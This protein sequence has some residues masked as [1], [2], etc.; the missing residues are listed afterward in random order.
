MERFEKIAEEK[1]IEVAKWR[2]FKDV[3]LLFRPGIIKSLDGGYQL[4]HYGMYKSYF[5]IGWR[6]LAKQRMYS[7]I[8]VGG[9]AIGIAAC[10]L[11]ALYIHQELNYD[12][13]FANGDRIYRVFRVSSFK[14]DVSRGAFF[15]SPFATTLAEE[16]PEIEQTG[17][18]RLGIGSYEVRCSDMLESSNEENLAFVDQSLLDIL[19]VPFIH[20]NPQNALSEPNTIVIT[21]S[22]S[23]KYFGDND[24][25]GKIF[26]LN[27]DESKQYKVTGVVPDFPFTSH[28]RYDFLISLAGREM[29]N[30][31][32]FNYLTYV[33]VRP[34]ADVGALEQKLISLVESYF[35]PPRIEM[36]LDD[37]I[38]WVKSFKFGL[39]P[40]QD[41]YLN[42]DDLGDNLKH[43]NVEYLWLFGSIATI[44]L[45]IACINFINLSTARSANRAKEIGIRKV[46]GSQRSSLIQQLLVES[47]MFSFFSFVLGMV[48]ALLLL[49]YFNTLISKTLIFPWYEWWWVLVMVTG[50]LL[51]GILAG[52]YPAFYLSSFR[53]ILVLKGDVRRGVE[54]SSMRSTLVIFQFTISIILIICTLIIDR[55]MYYVLNKQLGF[56]KEQVLLLHGTQTLGNKISVFK[57]EL[58]KLPKITS[59]SISEYLP[60]EGF[61]TDNGGWIKVGEQLDDAV[62]GQ[63]WSVDHDYV[64]TM[65]LKIVRGRDFSAL[66]PTDSQAVIINESLVKELNLKDPIGEQ[67][68]NWKGDWTVIGVVEDF[69]FESM[70]KEIRPLGMYM[71]QSLNTISIKMNTTDMGAMIRSVT[72]LWNEF[73]PNQTIRYSF[74]DQ[75][76][77][78]M[79]ED[80][81][82][83]RSIFSIFAILAIIVACLGLFA[84]S[85]FL[86]EQR[87][88]EISIRLVLGASINNILR[89]IVQNFLIL[90]I[91]SFFIAIPIAWYMMDQWLED[92]KYRIQIGWEVF[93][94][95]G[96]MAASIAIFTIS[97]QSIRAAF[98]NPVD[99]L[100]NE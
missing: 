66:M 74:L 91:I 76:Y 11:I 68:Y 63:H 95:A 80:V 42:L 23:A 38:K 16:Y 48:L 26:I 22:K 1:G 17:R 51:T 71:G 47:C 14:G 35:L 67:I 77:A 54:T 69:H 98:M 87:S 53:P 57:N 5:K 86:V 2:F 28:F 33:L 34:K 73:A 62:F 32:S 30:W 3:L 24:P 88:K 39:Q 9:F 75:Q 6:N 8:K 12:R 15:P 78:R 13:H 56:D 85:A 90:V 27:D 96:L 65:G 55:Q 19:Q 97:F 64:T 31:K 83:T 94:L 21:K 93:L 81:E 40:I 20:G 61:K 70:K 18:L 100:K 43:G 44:I 4:N 89:L 50:I 36:G 58:L 45:L 41:I 25:L 60:V 52:I 92:Y 46:V 7:A 49:P 72:A 82:R 37:D 59:V 10:L 79:Y 29:V 84:L 99:T